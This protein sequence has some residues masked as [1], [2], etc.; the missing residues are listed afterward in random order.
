MWVVIFRLFVHIYPHLK[1]SL[2][3]IRRKFSNFVS[4]TDLDV[5]R[6]VEDMSI[7]RHRASFV[8][9]GIQRIVIIT[10]QWSSPHSYDMFFICRVPLERKN[11]LSGTFEHVTLAIVFICSCSHGQKYC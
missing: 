8:D 5:C 4:M 3:S 9:I 11:I 7:H 10:A 6:P 1:H 2:K